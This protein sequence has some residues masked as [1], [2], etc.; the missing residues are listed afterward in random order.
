MQN[1]KWPKWLSYYLK[2]NAVKEIEKSIEIAEQKTMGEIVP[3]I[4]KS[5]L[6]L[7]SI[8][9]QVFMLLMITGFVF[10][11]DQNHNWAWLYPYP[12]NAHWPIGFLFVIFLCLFL[13]VVIVKFCSFIILFFLPKKWLYKQVIDRAELEFHRAKINR[14]QGATG[15]LLF[16]SLYERKAII[17]ADKAVNFNVKQETWDEIL[18]ALLQKIKQR[19][20]QEGILLAINEIGNILHSVLPVTDSDNPNELTNKLIIKSD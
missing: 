18:N 17:L 13:S 2:E 9:R 15:V 19:K 6:N 10:N 11:L 8:L 16:I 5:T 7:K 20:M 1:I 12:L 3:V 4:V 14:T